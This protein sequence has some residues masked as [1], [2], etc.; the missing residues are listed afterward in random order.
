VRE[1]AF[2]LDFTV[3]Y[4]YVVGLRGAGVYVDHVEGVALPGGRDAGDGLRGDEHG[5]DH[6]SA[7]VR[8][9]G[10]VGVGGKR[11]LR[12]SVGR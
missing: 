9:G 2:L 10:A 6:G 8:D 3:Y 1:L 5:D 11:D 12:V 7:A 4:L